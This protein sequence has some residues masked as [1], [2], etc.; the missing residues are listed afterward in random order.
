MTSAF[1]RRHLANDGLCDTFNAFFDEMCTP[2]CDTC[3]MS[4][5]VSVSIVMAFFSM[6]VFF[7]AARE[8]GQ[9]QE[10]SES[11][12]VFFY[13]LLAFTVFALIVLCYG[14]IGP[15]LAS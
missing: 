9:Y 4:I 7:A 3:F 6:L 1:V 8:C 10:S 5:L 11:T 12:V 14:F 13:A 15:R 2:H